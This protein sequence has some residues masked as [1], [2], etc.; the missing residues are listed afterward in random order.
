[1][2]AS[3]HSVNAPLFSSLFRS[4]VIRADPKANS[5]G[6]GE[7]KATIIP[8]NYLFFSSLTWSQVRSDPSPPALSACLS[9][10]SATVFFCSAHSLTTWFH[11]HSRTSKT[12]C[13][14]SRHFLI[15]A[16][17]MQLSYR[18]V[19]FVS[20]L[21]DVLGKYCAT[22]G[23]QG[24]DIKVLQVMISNSYELFIAKNMQRIFYAATVAGYL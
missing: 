17:L 20:R 14:Y 21:C 19:N 11:T 8:G 2:A 4:Y 7:W 18:Q 24:T 12:S 15:R 22:V 10:V 6:A 23:S 16:K 5:V 3:S 13:T 9:K 1:M